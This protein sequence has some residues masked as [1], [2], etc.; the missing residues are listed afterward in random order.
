[1]L[2]RRVIEGDRDDAELEHIQVVMICWLCTYIIR[3]A[4]ALP[5]PGA[6]YQKGQQ[7]RA[8]ERRF[9]VIERVCPLHKLVV[10]RWGSIL[11]AH[12]PRPSGA[13]S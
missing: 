13:R 12:L 4:V 6:A 8:G 1:M 10:G 9:V 11:C 5:D 7:D 3:V 2:K